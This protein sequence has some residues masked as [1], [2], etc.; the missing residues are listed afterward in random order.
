MLQHSASTVKASSRKGAITAL[1]RGGACRPAMV[2]VLAR[3]LPGPGNSNRTKR[4][5]YTAEPSLM[6]SHLQMR[7]LW[8]PR[9]HNL[10]PAVGCEKGAHLPTELL[11]LSDPGTDPRTDPLSLSQ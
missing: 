5:K 6:F 8:L 3:S 1:W 10:L 9:R 7:W 2:T 4:G 11:S